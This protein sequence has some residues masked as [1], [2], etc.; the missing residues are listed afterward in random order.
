M[1]TVKKDTFYRIMELLTSCAGRRGFTIVVK[2]DKIPQ[3]VK[4]IV[5][6]IVERLTWRDLPSLPVVVEVDKSMMDMEWEYI[7]KFCLVI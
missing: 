6:G 5:K 2:G 4:C 1:I 3:F 7:D